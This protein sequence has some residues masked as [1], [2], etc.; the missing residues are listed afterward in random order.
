MKIG[1]DIIDVKRISKLIKNG[2]FLKKVYTPEEV[3]YCRSKKKKAQHF[4]VRFATKEAVWKALGRN[5]I[6]HRDIG[7]KNMPDGKPVVLIKGKPR[8]DIAISL[9]H[10]DDY[11]TAVAIKT[12]TKF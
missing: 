7:V 3:R 11:A 5:D 1:I 12:N 8:K 4:A 6:W 9:S 2:K 10:T